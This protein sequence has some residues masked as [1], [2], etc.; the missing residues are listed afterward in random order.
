MKE[1][2][3]GANTF[4]IGQNFSSTENNSKYKIDSDNFSVTFGLFLG[5]SN[6]HIL[7]LILQ[8]YLLAR[9]PHLVGGF[10]K[11]IVSLSLSCY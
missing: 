10:V 5:Q 11:P 1:T 2:R 3:F 7:S 4:K 8:V 6:S 9:V